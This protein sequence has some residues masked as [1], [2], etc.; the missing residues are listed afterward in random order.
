MAPKMG[1][2]RPAWP[3]PHRIIC[4]QFGGHFLSGDRLGSG[5]K[6]TLLFI[7]V[8]CEEN[9][10]TISTAAGTVGIAAVCKALARWINYLIE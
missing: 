5:S 8:S 4:G 2:R 1:R 10:G 7:F 6:C 9:K 3:V